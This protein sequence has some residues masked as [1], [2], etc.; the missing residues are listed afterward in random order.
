MGVRARDNYLN[1]ADL[2]NETHD[3][4]FAPILAPVRSFEP[5]ILVSIPSEYCQVTCQSYKGGRPE[6]IASL[7]TVGMVNTDPAAAPILSMGCKA[8]QINLDG[9][10]WR[11]TPN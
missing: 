10:R 5:M 7:S 2:L 8:A 11:L 9:V 6:F 3:R 4:I 1:V